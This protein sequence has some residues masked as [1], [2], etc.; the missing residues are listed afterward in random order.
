MKS[1][2]IIETNHIS[3]EILDLINKVM[4]ASLSAADPES[5]VSSQI[6]LHDNTI[7]IGNR[8]YRLAEINQIY[9]VAIGKAAV[10]MTCAVKSSLKELV[11]GGFIISKQDFPQ[12]MK[13]LGDSFVFK[14]GNHPVPGQ[15]SLSSA[16]ELK[17][18]LKSLKLVENDLVIFLI[19]GG[20]S[21][22]ITKPQGMITI[23]EMQELTRMLLSCGAEINE[24]NAV[25]KHIDE[26][27][28][29]G[30][31]RWIFPAKS[32]SLIMSDV[33]GSPV[34]V[35]ASGPTVADESTYADAKTV[36]ERYQLFSTCPAS[37]MDVITKGI[38]GELADTEKTGSLLL[39]TTGHQ[40]VTS[41]QQA[42]EAG[43]IAAKECGFNAMLL[44]SYLDGEA[45][46][47][48]G[49]LASL[50]LQIANYNQPVSRPACIIAGGETTVTIK[51]DGLG[52]R[53]LE[54]ALGAVQS[55]AGVENSVMITFATDGEDGP[56]DAAGAFVT[57]KTFERGRALGITPDSYLQNND[58]YHYFEQLGNLIKIGSTGTNVND[59]N[60]IFIF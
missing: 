52:G 55:M 53:N 45:K 8:N 4:N 36:L 18:Y 28:G 46:Y 22:L 13:G 48:G 15:Q 51:G 33:I 21:S 31:L 11:A 17:Q 3:R 47:A 38:T 5:A 58:S 7:K 34:D 9:T 59:L 26:V 30:L 49:F 25:R 43:I 40:L 42:C 29:G 16:V 44:T 10:G 41:N 32:V 50:V 2:K 14:R 6:K 56:T 37:V 1:N 39:K 27:K 19:S 12:I 54:T 20:G 23:E 57:G 60:F 24:I 35:I